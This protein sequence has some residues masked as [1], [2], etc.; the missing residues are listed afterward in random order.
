M[1]SSKRKENESQ[2]DYRARLKSA[3]FFDKHR[4]KGRLLWHSKSQGTYIRAKHGDL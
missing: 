1:A 4:K 2:S 3:A